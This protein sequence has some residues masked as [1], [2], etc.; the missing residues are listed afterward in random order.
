MELRRLLSA[1]GAC[2]ITATMVLT[3]PGSIALA[4]SPARECA[5]TETAAQAKVRAG[6]PQVHDPN[7]LSTKEVSRIERETAEILR[8][9]G[10][11]NVAPAALINIPV[12]VHVIRKG[13]GRANGDLPD[14]M[15][16]NQ[17]A[18]LNQSFGTATGGAETNFRFFLQGINRVLN[19]GWY[20]VGYGSIAETNMKNALR[21]GN[22]KTLNLYTAS[23]GGG[24]LGWATFPSSY[25]SLPRMDG[26]VVLGESLPGGTAA[27]YN[28]GDTGTHEVGHWLG[29]YHTFQG[30]C[31]ASNDQV[32]DTPAESSPA[33]GC[34]AGRN[35]CAAAGVDPIHNFMDYT[36][37]SCMFQFTAGQATRMLA[38]WVAY[39]QLQ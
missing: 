7:H 2:A 9:R 12:V 33:F 17:I 19:T 39:R 29:L 25:A 31:N 38:Q 11:Q 26:V 15:I 37:D 18:V 4:H 10:D 27:P 22:A 16:Q 6:Y 23:I 36:D 30:G 21:V 14:A 20:T 34:P 35:T 13:A 3:A 5:E 32:A 28:L 24:L 1:A 8:Q